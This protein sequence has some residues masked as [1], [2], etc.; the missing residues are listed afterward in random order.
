M[1]LD[2]IYKM[3]NERKYTLRV[4]LKN[5]QDSKT[6]TATYNTFKLTENVS[7]ID[8][9]HNILVFVKVQNLSLII[10][11]KKQKFLKQWKLIIR[12]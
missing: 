5:F 2:N 11:D 4:T 1:G 10:H 8:I 3:T 6:L 7:I 12:L 9:F